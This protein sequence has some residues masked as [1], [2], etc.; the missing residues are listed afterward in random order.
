MHLGLGISIAPTRARSKPPPRPDGEWGIVGVASRSADVVRALRE[1]GS[2]YSVLT[3]GGDTV[4]AQVDVHSELLVAAD[5]PG[6]VTG[7]IADPR[8]RVD[9]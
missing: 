6:R 9:P 5:D 4:E 1:Q 2:A 3:L 8:T 7:W